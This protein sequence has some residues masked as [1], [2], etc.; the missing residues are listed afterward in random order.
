MQHKGFFSQPE[1]WGHA[2]SR[3]L[4]HWQHRLPAIMP[5]ELGAAWSGSAVVDQHDTSGFF[6]GKPGLVCIYT[7]YSPA[8]DGRQSQGMAYSA[9]GVTFTKYAKNPI[10]PQLRYQP[11]Q[12]DDHDFRDPKVFWHEPTKRWIM[13]VAGGTLRFYSSPNLRDWTFES[14]NSDIHTECPDFFP[15]PLDGDPTQTRWVLSG[16]GNWYR[17]RQLRRPQV[18]A[19]RRQ[20]PVYLWP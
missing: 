6:G 10:I 7:Y 2:V 18:Y 5:D 13:V 3:D 14:I 4:L 8:D 12:P 15:L 11:G 9:D 1:G 19:R 17:A 16:G 20:H